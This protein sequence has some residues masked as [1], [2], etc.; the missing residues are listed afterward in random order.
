MRKLILLLVLFSLMGLSK[1]IVNVLNWTGY[2]PP[3]ILTQFE[4]TSGITVNYNMFE[5]DG[6]LYTKLT[7]QKNTYDIAG[8]S[9]FTIA[10]MNKIGMIQPLDKN[11]LTYYK[12]LNP[13]LLYSPSDPHGNY[14]IPNFWG[15]TGIVVNKKYID[16]KSISSW[17]DLWQKR[18]RGT[19]LIPDDPRE[20]FNFILISLGYPIND[21]NPEHIKQAY[22][23]L[24]KLLPNIKIF[25]EAGEET[26][27]ADDDVIAGV[28]LSGDAFHAQESNPDI[29]YIYPKEG[30]AIWLDC[31]AI[32]KNPP[33]VNNAYQF[34]NYTMQP[35]ITAQIASFAGFATA[36]LAAIKLLP[37][38]MR[39]N[40]ILYPDPAVI[41]HAAVENEQDVKIRILIEHYWELLKLEA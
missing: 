39:N 19:L 36:N 4:K 40:S 24:K 26:L 30:V 6:S 35:K 22:L 2:M 28:S 3:E 33:N 25:N 5:S 12:N 29:T 13:R 14:C 15:T 41:A 34:L 16:P 9:S 17:N 8:P 37:D 10:Q 38:D 23:K 1:E 7:L 20:V 32:P 27:F 21:E 18:F 11:Q 31:L